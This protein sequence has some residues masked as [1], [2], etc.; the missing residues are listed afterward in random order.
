MLFSI[1][2]LSYVLLV[3]FYRPKFQ[4]LVFY[5]SYKV[6]SKRKQSS[7]YTNYAECKQLRK[8]S[9]LREAVSNLTQSLYS[10]YM[11]QHIN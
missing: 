6:V 4:R 1:L 5:N 3:H 2:G 7:I 11:P 8:I 10:N 9:N